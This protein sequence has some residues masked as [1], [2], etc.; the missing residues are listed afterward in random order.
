[1]L[2][3]PASAALAHRLDNAGREGFGRRE[4]AAL[5]LVC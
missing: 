5:D 2:S 4:H 1:V 3:V